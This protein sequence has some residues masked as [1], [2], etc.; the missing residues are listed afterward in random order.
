MPGNINTAPVCPSSKRW[1]SREAASIHAAGSCAGR[2]MTGSTIRPLSR[3]GRLIMTIANA[4]GTASTAS[5][6]R[7]ERSAR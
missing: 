2:S 1:S 7:D 5:R 6:G 4:S 3:A